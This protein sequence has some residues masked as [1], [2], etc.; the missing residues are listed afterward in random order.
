MKCG[1]K[2]GAHTLSWQSLQDAA[3]G[4]SQVSDGLPLLLCRVRRLWENW[5]NKVKFICLC[6]PLFKRGEHAF[7]C[8]Y[9][10]E[11]SIF[12]KQYL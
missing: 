9:T 10:R 2:W 4:C 11:H 3:A 8:P 5:E 12:E 6:S 1:C 7:F